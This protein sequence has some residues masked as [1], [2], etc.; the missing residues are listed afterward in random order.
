MS[1]SSENRSQRQPEEH[2]CTT[3]VD[4]DRVEWAIRIFHVNAGAQTNISPNQPPMD[5]AVSA[6]LTRGARNIQPQIPLPL[7]I[8]SSRLISWAAYIFRKVGWWTDVTN[9]VRVPSLDRQEK[10]DQ[11]GRIFVQEY[12]LLFWNVHP[13][14]ISALANEWL[15]AAVS[16]DNGSLL[17]RGGLPIRAK[18]PRRC[19]SMRVL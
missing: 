3:S 6:F 7:E 9:T 13:Q 16:I 12:P 8:R 4:L 5:P 2:Q 1:T 10:W 15:S 18:R 19:L 11:A 17:R 14:Q